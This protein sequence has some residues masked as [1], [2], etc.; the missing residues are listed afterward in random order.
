MPDI[1]EVARVAIG[2][3]VRDGELHDPVRKIGLSLGRDLAV[4][5]PARGSGLNAAIVGFADACRQTG[6]VRCD[7]STISDANTC[8]VR[9]AGCEEML[10]YRVSGAGRSVCSF[11]EGL[12]EAYL[13]H[14][15]PQS[16]LSVHESKCLGQ[17]DDYCE[18]LIE[19][20]ASSRGIW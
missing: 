1:A 3:V 18:F 13:K 19:P 20:L 5:C 15:V 17:G 16:N 4:A 10:G 14:Q 9:F 6:F 7:M 12:L 8:R 2:L 11:D